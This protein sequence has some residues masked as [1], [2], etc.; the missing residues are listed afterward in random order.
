MK[1]R[2]LRC[3]G[4]SPAGGNER[5]LMVR[6]SQWHSERKSE[7]LPHLHHGRYELRDERAVVERSRR[8][9]QALG[10]AR[11]SW[12]VNRLDVDPVALEQHI[13]RAL[14]EFRVAHYD[15]HDVRAVRQNG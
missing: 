15:R 6:P 13:A 9:A 8:N 10:A 7:L 14:A 11:Y 3:V 2:V 12:I 5:D 1:H 4:I